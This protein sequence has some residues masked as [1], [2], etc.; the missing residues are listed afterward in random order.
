MTSPFKKTNPLLNNKARVTESLVQ[1]EAE[2]AVDSM[3]DDSEDEVD[4]VNVR[5]SA[6]DL[7]KE[8]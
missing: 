5:E 3:E 1:K 4:E 6:R 8:V 7:K 2:I